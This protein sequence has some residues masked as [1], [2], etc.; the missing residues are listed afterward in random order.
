MI[1]RE[2]LHSPQA[3]IQFEILD[4]NMPA[5]SSQCVEWV[6]S[7][8]SEYNT[9]LFG[10]AEAETFTIAARVD[11]QLVGGSVVSLS[12]K[13]LFI[14]MLWVEPEW[15]GR[16]LGKELV[17]KSEHFARSRDAQGAWVDTFRSEAKL[18]Y[19]RLGYRSFGQIEGFP[20]GFTRFFLSRKFE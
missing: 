18:F 8:L 19:E 9:T 20:P 13:W 15:Q 1:S 10:P 12:W 3:K 11:G 2:T 6:Q 7:R 4:R 5:A 14:K 16:G 17:Q